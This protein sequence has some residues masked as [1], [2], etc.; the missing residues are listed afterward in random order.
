MVLPYVHASDLLDEVFQEPKSNNQVIDIGN[1]KQAVG[2]AIFRP[3][4]A[5][6]NW[7][8]V[9]VQPLYIRVTKFILR[10]TLILGV[11]MGIVVWVRYVY[12]QWDEKVEKEMVQYLWNIVIGI[13][14]AFS[15]LVIVELAQSV[16]RSSIT[17]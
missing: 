11:T 7:Q 4:V 10:A 3:T 9:T 12:A 14:I 2:N 15:A 6:V 16:T 17:F 8:L 5:I 13:I 1:N